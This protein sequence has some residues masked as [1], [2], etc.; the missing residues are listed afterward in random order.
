MY[1]NLC[2][3]SKNLNILIKKTINLLYT[4]VVLS[5]LGIVYNEFKRKYLDD[6]KYSNSSNVGNLSLPFLSI[7]ILILA[8]NEIGSSLD[9][10]KRFLYSGCDIFIQ[11]ILTFFKLIHYCI[12]LNC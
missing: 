10:Y 5:L 6:E 8:F 11:C 1:P 12:L 3:W 2:F 7:Q 4:F 9:W